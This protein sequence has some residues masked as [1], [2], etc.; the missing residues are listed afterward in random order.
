MYTPPEERDFLSYLDD[1]KYEET[2]KDP[3][4]YFKSVQ[5]INFD[6]IHHQCRE[7]PLKMP[8]SYYQMITKEDVILLKKNQKQSFFSAA[9]RN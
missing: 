5:I 2:M 3:D 8:P 9:I 1:L 4:V 7:D 6:M